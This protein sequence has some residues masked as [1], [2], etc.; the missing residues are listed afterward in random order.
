MLERLPRDGVIVSVS[1]DNLHIRN[2]RDPLS[3]FRVAKRAVLRSLEAGF[4][5]NVM[6]NT[7]KL[8]MHQLDGLLDWAIE[9]RVSV[10]SV[11]FSP[12]GRGHDHPELENTPEDVAFL[13]GFWVREK[14]WEHAFH[15][16][17]GLCVGSVFDYGETL[18][19]MTRRC[20]SGRYLCY[21]ASDGTVFPC[22]SC[23][24][25]AILSPGSVRDGGLA[26]LWAS[27][28]EI[29]DFNWDNFADTCEGCPINH[30]DYYCS[31]RCPAFSYARHGRFFDCGASPFQIGSTIVRTSLLKGSI[32]GADDGVPT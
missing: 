20:P 7:H 9:H 14:E 32:L 25:E 24:S 8:N 4:N 15:R 29:R 3:D 10:R 12:V 2:P 5:T 31:S 26:A 23:A 16:D 28:W 21:V 19:F 11:P 30:A 18:G 22:T 1:F 27:H 17:V 6:T 13:A